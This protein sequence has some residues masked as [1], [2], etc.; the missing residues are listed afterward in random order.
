MAGD[1]GDESNKGP[2]P[3]KDKNLDKDGNPSNGKRKRFRI[4][5]AL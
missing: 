1:N 2:D 3:N 4:L 5:H